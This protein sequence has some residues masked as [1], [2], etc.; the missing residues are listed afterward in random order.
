MSD[1]SSNAVTAAP[2]IAFLIAVTL[3]QTMQTNK[4]KLF[5]FLHTL[6]FGTMGILIIAFF[7]RIMFYKTTT[8]TTNTRASEESEKGAQE[9]AEERMEEFALGSM[10]KKHRSSAET[11]FD[12][13]N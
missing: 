9:R 1:Q 5:W 10:T 8:K 11:T 2:A 12:N 4:F 7:G 6:S 13:A 3:V